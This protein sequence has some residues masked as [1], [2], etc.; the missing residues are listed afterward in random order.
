VSETVRLK[1]FDFPRTLWL[2]VLPAATLAAGFWLWRSSGRV[3]DGHGADWQPYAAAVAIFTLAFIGLAYSLYPYVVIDRLTIWE[4]AAHPTALH[5][6]LIGA[7]LVLPFI[8][9]YTILSY[10]IFGGKATKDLYH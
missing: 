10:R 9:G 4:A 8:V 5:M 2:M 6:L 3:R 7:V 1:W